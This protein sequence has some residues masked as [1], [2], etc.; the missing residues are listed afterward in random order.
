LQFIGH[1]KITGR[2]QSGHRWKY[3]TA[4][5]NWGKIHTLRVCNTFYNNDNSKAP[6]EHVILTSLV[7]LNLM[8]TG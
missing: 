6:Q 7:L 2:G 4:C 5:C 3:D 1:V 8:R